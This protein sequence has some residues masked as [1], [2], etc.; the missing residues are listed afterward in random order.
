MNTEQQS[1]K[2]KL[3]PTVLFGVRRFCSRGVARAPK[4]ASKLS[5]LAHSKEDAPRGLEKILARLQRI[6]G[7]VVRRSRN[8]E[9]GDSLRPRVFVVGAVFDPP[10]RRRIPHSLSTWSRAFPCLS[11]PLFARL[12]P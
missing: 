12:R 5:K 3:R 4:S 1:R 7:L 2:P 6:F 9:L 8:Q 10:R 11:A